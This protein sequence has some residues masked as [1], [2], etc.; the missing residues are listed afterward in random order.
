[1]S[2]ETITV[3]S[4]V[5]DEDPW[6][7]KIED[8][9]LRL[10]QL[11]KANTPE[12]VKRAISLYKRDLKIP[13]DQRE[14]WSKLMIDPRTAAKIE[15]KGEKPTPSIIMKLRSLLTP[16]DEESVIRFL[17]R[18]QSLGFVTFRQLIEGQID[19]NRDDLET[20]LVC[21][22]GDL[23]ERNPSDIRNIVLSGLLKN[24][25]FVYL[26]PE[27]S[28]TERDFNWFKKSLEGEES[29]RAYAQN[30]IGIPRPWACG[31]F[32]VG[33]V[34]LVCKK[35]ATPRAST[36]S[37]PEGIAQGYLYADIDQL[38]THGYVCIPMGRN[39]EERFMKRL[40]D[41][42]DPVKDEKIPL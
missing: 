33:V 7:E 42:F 31:L 39:L 37:N 25:R 14:F 15:E 40:G 11:E 21:T 38:Q 41:A 6:R 9:D 18:R 5:E 10:E 23:R 16:S 20:V 34:Y 30:V 13:A 3:K 1:M 22:C 8:P 24:V 27:G 35:R 28:D 17:L 26:Y 19:G 2:D 32:S 12:D 36:G 29:Y 4:P